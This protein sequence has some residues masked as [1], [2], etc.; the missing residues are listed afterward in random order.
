MLS[1][2]PRFAARSLLFALPLALWMSGQAF[3]GPVQIFE[4]DQH[5][6]TASRVTDICPGS[7]DGVPTFAQPIVFQN[8][9]IYR[10][11][12]AFYGTEPWRLLANNSAAQVADID[13]LN[14][15]F[16]NSF[17]VHDNR[18][19]FSAI[20]SEYGREI[21]VFDGSQTTLLQDLH[22]GSASALAYPL[23]SYDGSLIFT[24]VTDS[25][26][27]LW[28]YDNGAPTLI[29]PSKITYRAH[30]HQGLLYLNHNDGMLGSELWRYDGAQLQLDIEFVAGETGGHP[31]L[32]TSL[33]SELLYGAMQQGDAYAFQGNPAR[34]SVTSD[35]IVALAGAAYYGGTD[36]W[37]AHTQDRYLKRYDGVSFTNILQ[38]EAG[39]LATHKSSVYFSDDSQSK[40]RR[41][42]N[43]VVE[44]VADFSTR[45]SSALTSLVEFN[46]QLYF[47][48]ATGTHGREWW[49]LTE[50][51]VVS[52][53]YMELTPVWDNRLLWRLSLALEGE[54]LL[55]TYA[56]YQVS[57]R[58]GARLNHRELIELSSDHGYQYT[59]PAK[60]SSRSDPH[61][62]ATLVI[63]FDTRG[64]K[65]FVDV[66]TS[67]AGKTDPKRTSELASQAMQ[68]GQALTYRQLQ[69]AAIDS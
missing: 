20:N 38:V 55:M 21:W 12:D 14:G 9:L 69:A 47:T 29:Q 2:L 36:S 28:R 39:E 25:G 66:Q 59:Q 51:P 22:T 7:C 8:Q 50:A 24:G 27:G 45:S 46:N 31:D 49:A 63:G 67:S 23:A 18:L 64:Q 56:V 35:D 37:P 16:P 48:A 10:G 5:L 6:P 42:R 4:I 32:F 44:L 53:V 15:S 61:P 52:K 34:G 3:A 13:P 11:Y 26:Q 19:Y 54:P 30:A 40:L 43:G 60:R 68:F 57:E 33:G 65:L 17:V 1:N 62:V 58:N 41:Y